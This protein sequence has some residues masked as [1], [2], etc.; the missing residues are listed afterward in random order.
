M[1]C[2]GVVSL[3]GGP[4]PLITFVKFLAPP[5]PHNPGQKLPLPVAIQLQRRCRAFQMVAVVV[6]AGVGAAAAAAAVTAVCRAAAAVVPMQRA[7]QRRATVLHAF[8]RDQPV[9]ATVADTACSE[10]LEHAL[11][12]RVQ[13]MQD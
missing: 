11:R 1:K 6:A 13:V 4:L 2:I 5:C 9:G 10:A 3:R 12:P 8:V 7:L